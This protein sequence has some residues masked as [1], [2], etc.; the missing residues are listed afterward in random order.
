MPNVNPQLL[1][2]MQRLDKAV[3]IQKQANDR[4][5]QQLKVM[6]GRVDQGLKENS[7][8]QNLKSNLERNMGNLMVPGNVGDINKVIWPFWFSIPF[9]RVNPGQNVRTQFTV[10]QEAGFSF[11]ALTKAV[12]DFDDATNELTYI[13]PDEPAIG[14]SAGLSII[15]RDA[16]SSREF[17]NL[18]ANLD[19]LGNP[20]FPTSLPTPYFFLPNSI[21]EYNIINDHPT[22]IYF[23]H[24]TMFGYRVRIEGS[25]NILSTVYA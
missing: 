22:N 8:V 16:Q 9:T 4:K 24:L 21:I 23:V 5:E 20:R 15:I 13:D 25:Q 3:S 18:P 19:T 17:F 14:E 7:S 6:E 12:Y 2:E 10:T 1:A 11:M